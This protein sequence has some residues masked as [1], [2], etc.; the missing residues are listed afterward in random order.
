LD[1]P[2]ELSDLIAT[3]RWPLTQAEANRQN[4][5]SGPIPRELIKKLVPG[6]EQLFLLPPPFRTIA[7]RRERGER[8]E[9][10]GGERNFWREYGALDEIDPQRAVVIGDFGLGSD[11]V[12]VLDY[13]PARSPSLIRLAW[14]DGALRPHWVPFFATFS[15]FARA[16]QLRERRWR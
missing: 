16:F 13:R 6:E 1:L 7:E 8:G 5:P 11:A 12:I 14:T 2:S 9:R 10:D 4:L 3:G 15:E